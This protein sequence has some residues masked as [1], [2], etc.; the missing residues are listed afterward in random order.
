MP[1]HHFAFNL[2]VLGV[3]GA[4]LFPSPKSVRAKLAKG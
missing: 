1:L 4:I 2:G 3:L